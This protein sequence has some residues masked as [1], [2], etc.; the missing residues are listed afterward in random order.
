MNQWIEGYLRQF[1]TGRQNNWSTLLPIVEFAHNFWKHEHTKHSPHELIMGMNPSASFNVPKDPVPTVQDR[2]KELIK[3]RQDTQQAIQNCIKP[4]K[5]PRTLV[6]GDMV[7]LDARNLK[8]KT[9]SKKLSPRR[10]GPYPV[11]EQ[12]SPVTYRIKLPSSLRIK[13]VFHIDLLTPFQE[14]KEHGENYPRLPPELIDGEEEFEVEEII[15]DRTFRRKKQYLV[16]WQGY[17][18]TDNTWV[19]AQ[20][21]NAPRLLE[22]Y[23]LSKA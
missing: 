3:T 19:N 22:E 2:L 20:D 12:I 13:N 11:L 21:L 17:P 14:T 9:P 8:I 5:I 23:H 6:S 7:W 18:M 4:I 15:N 16:K 10:Y 1:V